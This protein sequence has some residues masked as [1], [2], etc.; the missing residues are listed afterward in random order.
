MYLTSIYLV[1][2]LSTKKKVF[3][4]ESQNCSGWKGQLEQ[5]AQNCI[6][7][8]FEQLHIWRIYK[9]SG[10]PI[11]MFDHP[12]SEKINDFHRF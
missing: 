10:E 2:W 12:H 1:H 11:P 7:L 9:L 4:S 3:I 8:S 5:V 6:W